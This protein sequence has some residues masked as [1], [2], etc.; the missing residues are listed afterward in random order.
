MISYDQQTQH[1]VTPQLAL[2]MNKERMR[3][4]GLQRSHGEKRGQDFSVD[5]GAKMELT[6][7]NASPKAKKRNRSSFPFA[8]PRRQN[9]QE[10]DQ[11]AKRVSIGFAHS[12]ADQPAMVS[13][14]SVR[15]R[16]I[17]T[18]CSQMVA[19]ME[20]C[21]RSTSICSSIMTLTYPLSFHE[22]RLAR[23]RSCRMAHQSHQQWYV[24]GGLSTVRWA[25]CAQPID[26]ACVFLRDPNKPIKHVSVETNLIC[27]C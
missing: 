11:R 18:S 14:C 12:C 13:W 25:T 21:L 3:S 23:L 19:Q 22:R 4:C 15:M 26:K 16:C 20:I 5:K 6:I 10:D 8:N 27:T 17:S 9:K 24:Q 7:R 2:F 1:P